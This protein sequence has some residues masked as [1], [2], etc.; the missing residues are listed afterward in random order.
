MPLCRDRSPS[1]RSSYAPLRFPTVL[2]VSFLL[3]LVAPLDF[4]LRAHAS[5]A[6][7]AASAHPCQLDR[8]SQLLYVNAHPYLENSPD[9]LIQRFPELHDLRPSADQHDLDRI[10]S[11]TSRRVQSYF[12]SLVDLVA[13][14]EIDQ[15]RLNAKGAVKEKQH[16]RYSYIILLNRDETPTQFEEYRT[17]SQGNPVDQSGP[18]SGF[19]TT[20]G[21]ALI[22]AHFLPDNLPDSTF[23]YLGSELLDSHN[24]YVVA[25][26]QLPDRASLT[27]FVSGE[28]GSEPFLVQG[29]AWVDQNTFEIIHIRTD[30]LAPRNDVGLAVQSTEVTFSEV[31]LPDSSLPLLVPYHVTVSS[32]YRGNAYRNDHFYSDYRRFHVSVKMAPQ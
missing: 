31:Q 12:D 14:E 8:R 22:C 2:L 30:L 6:A 10:L 9:Q 3:P 19:N 28:W 26:A 1:G 25:F 21:F 13:Q 20:S 4:F 17:D 16:R 7:T 32:K 15:Q 23:R 27:N 11:N 29:I 18:N 24:T 5:P